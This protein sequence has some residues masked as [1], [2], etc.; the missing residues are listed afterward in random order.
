M[1]KSGRECRWWAVPSVMALY[2][3]I[4]FRTPAAPGVQSV[5]RGE[6]AVGKAGLRQDATFRE[7][8]AV[9]LDKAAEPQRRVSAMA[10]LVEL[11]AELAPE[12][13]SAAI[14]DPDAGVRRSS[15]EWLAEFRDKRGLDILAACVQAPSCPRR[16]QAARLLGNAGNPEYAS[17]LATQLRAVMAT[18]FRGDAWIGNVSDRA[19]LN[20]AVVALA[21]MGRAEDRELIF[22]VVRKRPFGDPYFLEAL[23]FQRSDEGVALLWSAYEQLRGEATCSNPG[24][25]VPGLLALS[26]LGDP[27]A[28]E[29]LRDIL[30]GVGTV[31]DEFRGAPA[32]CADRSLAFRSLR[33]RDA[34]L[35]AGAVFQVAAAEPE[36]PATR[37]AWEA[38]GVMHPSGFSERLL[39]LAVSKK[40][41][42][43]LVSRDLLNKVVIASDPQL[44]EAFWAALSVENPPQMLPSKRLVKMGLGRLMFSGTK[45][46]TGD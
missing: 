5:G 24:L 35:F 41:H 22:E 25:G 13:I 21:R 8:K 23:S 31:P 39:Q 9:L 26:R 14:S 40:P 18:S 30:R 34:S 45:E 19:L 38:L 10:T 27:I 11:N 29:R 37:W 7:A 6:E 44:N 28:V 1:S 15:A 2:A 33:P 42:W 3:V 32:L 20:N 12:P 17:I 43:R 4:G 46:W 16:H 36:G